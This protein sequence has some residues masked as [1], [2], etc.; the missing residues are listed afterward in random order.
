MDIFQKKNIRSGFTL[1]EI[2]VVIA[3]IGIMALSIGNI[4]FT[5]KTESEKKNRL[6]Q[7]I[8][9]LIDKAKSDALV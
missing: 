6:I 2:L 3:L 5:N 7:S 1:I 8:V 4:S 9:S